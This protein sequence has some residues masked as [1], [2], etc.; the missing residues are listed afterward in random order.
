MITEDKCG[1]DFLTY[2]NRGKSL[3][4]KINVCLVKIVFHIRR[5]FLS[6]VLNSSTA[7]QQTVSCAC[8]LYT[9]ICWQATVTIMAAFEHVYIRL[10]I[11]EMPLLIENPTDCEIR[12]VIR[13][14]SAKGVKAV[15]ID[16]NICEVYGQNI[17]SDG[18]VCNG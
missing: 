2:T 5:M 4:H 13:Y 12:S 6:T 7:V 10:Y 15:E 17:M 3:N 14:L 16:R 18:M 8:T 1:I 11:F 9:Y